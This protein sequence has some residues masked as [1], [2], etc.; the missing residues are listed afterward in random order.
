MSSLETPAF[1]LLSIDFEGTCEPGGVKEFGVARFGVSRLSS[2]QAHSPEDVMIESENFANA[3]HRHRKF[4]FGTSTKVSPELLPRVVAQQV[5]GVRSINEDVTPGHS[6]DHDF[7]FM[8]ALGV[9]IERFD[10]FIGIVDTCQ[11]AREILGRGM[12]LK[13]LLETLRIPFE[14][15]QLH[16]AGNDAH[17]TLRAMLALLYWQSTGKRLDE[18]VARTEKIGLLP[19]VV[20]RPVQ[21]PQ[22]IEMQKEAAENVE[23]CFDSTLFANEHEAEA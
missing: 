9:P 22:G 20:L 17:Y 13:K 16:C 4:A 7:K 21:S 3:S 8:D 12:S 14:P 18:A 10:N 2:I 6:I 15:T 5:G 19:S 1:D 23:E 11:L